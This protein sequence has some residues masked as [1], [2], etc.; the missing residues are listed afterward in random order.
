MTSLSSDGR[1]GAASV[2]KIV[3]FCRQDFGALV[4]GKVC[5]VHFHSLGVIRD[6]LGAFTQRLQSWP[7]AWLQTFGFSLKWLPELG[8]A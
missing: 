7:L 3:G 4:Q 2:R 5:R 6:P 1:E 8:S